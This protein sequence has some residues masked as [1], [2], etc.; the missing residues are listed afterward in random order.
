MSFRLDGTEVCTQARY[1]QHS[2]LLTK[3]T[4]VAILI[5]EGGADRSPLIILKCRHIVVVASSNSKV[6]FW[7]N[8]DIKNTAAL[9]KVD[10]STES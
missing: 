10:F 6:L 5:S 2:K 9:R 4:K 3:V 7:L 1:A 8:R